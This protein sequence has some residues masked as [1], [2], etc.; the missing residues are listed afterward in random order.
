MSCSSDSFANASDSTTVWALAS[1]IGRAISDSSTSLLNSS[2]QNSSA[3][4]TDNSRRRNS[5]QG[6]LRASTWYCLARYSV[7]FTFSFLTLTSSV[8]TARNSCLKASGSTWGR[9]IILSFASLKPEKSMAANTLDRDAKTTLCAGI[10]TLL[11]PTS[12]MISH[13]SRRASIAP[14]SAARLPGVGPTRPM[15]DAPPNIPL[16][17]VSGESALYLELSIFAMKLT[18]GSVGQAL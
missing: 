11:G 2:S 13:S 14:K 4:F 5:T 17:F 18:W 7:D 16:L 8:Y 3:F 1:I 15:L 10:F 12:N 9:A 6:A